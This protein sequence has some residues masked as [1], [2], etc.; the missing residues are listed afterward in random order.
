MNIILPKNP[1]DIRSYYNTA[2]LN[3]SQKSNKNLSE[4]DCEIDNQDIL[5]FGVDLDNLKSKICEKNQI[6]RS[7]T[8]YFVMN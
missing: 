8:S 5:P 7:I 6:Q 3:K 1:C 2:D 4:N